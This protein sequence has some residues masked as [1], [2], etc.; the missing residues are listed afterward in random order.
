MIKLKYIMLHSTLFISVSL[1]SQVGINSVTPQQTLHV[2]GDIQVTDEI[3]IG[4]DANNAGNAGVAGEA[5]VSRGPGLP[6]EWKDISQ[7]PSNPGTVIVVNGQFAI[8]QEI[9]VQLGTDYSGTASPNSATP[10][11]IGNLDSIILDNKNTYTGS[12]SSNSF[13][14]IAD[15]VYQVYLNMQ[16]VTTANTYPVI[17]IWDDTMNVWVTNV[18]DLTLSNSQQSYTII[19]SIP[20]YASRTYSFRARNSA[21]YTIRQLSGGTTG[22]GPVSQVTIKRLK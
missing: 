19:T 22:S 17:G 12:S 13:Q 15:G 4:G 14:V 11:A 7:T 21:N 10:T 9:V 16:L 3:N 18:N 5:L 6:P 8:A 2:N 1:F 20:M